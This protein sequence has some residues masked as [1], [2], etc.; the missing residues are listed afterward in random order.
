MFSC[1]YEYTQ[2]ALQYELCVVWRV[3]TNSIG[4][5]TGDDGKGTLSHH[6]SGIK[7]ASDTQQWHGVIFEASDD[8]WAQKHSIHELVGAG[9]PVAEHI[10]TPVSCSDFQEVDFEGN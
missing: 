3:D 9:T 5:S 2:L 1:P 8:K 7:G 4:S 10:I 6:T